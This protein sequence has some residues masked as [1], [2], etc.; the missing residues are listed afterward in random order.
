M[1]RSTQLSAPMCT[2]CHSPQSL[3]N[4]HGKTL[5]FGCALLKDQTADTFEWLFETFLIANNGKAPGT[6]ITDQD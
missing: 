3:V 1:Y 4:N 6:V 2:T 5:L